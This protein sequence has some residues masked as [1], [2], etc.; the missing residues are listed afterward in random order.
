MKK[1][2]KK[3]LSLMLVAVLLATAIPFQALAAEDSIDVQVKIYVN[4]EAKDGTKKLTVDE[5]GVK[6][7]DATA[8]GLLNNTNNREF[9]R[10][11]NNSG[12]VVTGNELTYNWL[13]GQEGYSLKAYFKNP[14]TGGDDSGE[15]EPEATTYSVNF[16]NGDEWIGQITINENGKIV[17]GSVP[18]V[19]APDGKKFVGWTANGFP[20]VPGTTK[21]TND[22]V[23]GA[24]F[25]EITSGDSGS[26][27]ESTDTAKLTVIVKVDGN[28][29]KSTKTV[30][31]GERRLSESTITSVFS[32][33]SSS[34]YDVY[35]GGEKNH[36]NVKIGSAGGE[37][38]EM[39]DTY[40]VTAD[41]TVTVKLEAKNT[42][43]GSSDND[44]DDD[45]GENKFPY[46]VYLRIYRK[47]NLSSAKV[48]N[49]TNGIAADGYVDMADVKNV[50]KQY[51]TA[52]D[53]DGIIYDGIYLYEGNWVGSFAYN[54]RKYE[55]ISDINTKRKQQTVNLVV[56]IDNAKS[57]TS[58]SSTSDSTNYK[59]GDDIYMT[60]T[61]MGLSLAALAGVYYISKKRAVR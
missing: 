51:Y 52:E 48:V 22:L 33:Y 59:T 10:W 41:T 58:S 53:D 6:L 46:E 11:E 38:Y 24:E 47:S 25:E 56:V 19:T 23:V 40:N 43:G 16:Y 5:S 50:V 45:T 15:Q 32:G 2:C 35:A 31:K 9:L 29:Y 26:S 3:L 55:S 14:T 20:Y 18:Q 49:I 39:G 37:L 54:E 1:V 21:L 57:K 28:E 36:F 34:K 44:D 8:M 42:S 12:T 30:D 4:G 60:V 17:D 61:V 7:D 13:K 27:S